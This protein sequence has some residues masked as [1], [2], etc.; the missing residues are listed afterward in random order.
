M[1]ILAIIVSY[2]F[3]P[4]M[5]KCL[6]SLR[7]S[8]YPIDI[9][10]VDNHSQD[11]TLAVLRDDYPDVK[12]IAN[13]DNLGFGR[14]NNI[15]MA[16]ALEHHYDGVLLLNEDA[17][18]QRDTLTRLVKA[19]ARYTHFGILSPIHLTGRGDELEKGFAHYIGVSDLKALPKDTIVE[20]N[21]ID[22]AI[23]FMP[24]AAI[25]SVGMFAH[26]FQHYG[27]DKDLTNRLRHYGWKTGYLPQA[28]G[29]HARE[30]RVVT[31]QS[32]LYSVWVYLLSEYT[33]INYML[34]VAFAKS[35]LAAVKKA[36]G[37]ALRARFR[38]AGAY[39]RMAF[40]LMGRTPQVLV[41]RRESLHVNLKN[42]E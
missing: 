34:P 1:S 30:N 40:T 15:G 32:R 36:L 9:L 21:F 6:G 39:L 25:Q 17:W 33:N 28:K 4:W 7:Q 35:V 31:R 18:V 19:A 13:S 26:I 8:D 23:W 37:G 20:A 10:V 42:Y 2:N 14:A 3:V 27:E 24:T 29:H 5:G 12:V 16:Y 22:A 38:D 11:N 41:T